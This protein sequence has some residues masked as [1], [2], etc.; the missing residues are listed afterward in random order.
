MPNAAS[1][2]RRLATMRASASYVPGPAAGDQTVRLQLVEQRAVDARCS[3]SP[4]RSSRTSSRRSRRR[5]SA[6]AAT[7][8][9]GAL[10]RRSGRV[11]PSVEGVE[12]LLDD[13]QRQVVV[14]LG[15][16]HV[17]QAREVGVRKLR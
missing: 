9:D 8:G 10:D 13:A 17:A 15:G 4:S 11:L 7:S 3:S 14:P 5:E 2:R 6:D 16:E 12:V 1:S